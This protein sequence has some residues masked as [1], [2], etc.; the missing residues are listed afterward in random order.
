[1]KNFS[2]TDMCLKESVDYK[3]HRSTF[4]GG[5]IAMGIAFVFMGLPSFMLWSLQP[6]ATVT[7]CLLSV[8]MGLPACG[9]GLWK[10]QNICKSSEKYELFDAILKNPHPAWRFIR[11]EILL[12]DGTRLYSNG[13]FTNSS[14]SFGSFDEWNNKRVVVALDKTNERVVVLKKKN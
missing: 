12:D 3:F 7:M 4:R 8:L 14:F 2:K 5:L 9:Y 1:M 6:Y 10:M 11:F 13:V